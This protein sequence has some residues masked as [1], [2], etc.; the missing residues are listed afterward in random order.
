[1][2]LHEVGVGQFVLPI[3]IDRRMEPRS[4]SGDP[5]LRADD[6]I[7]GVQLERHLPLR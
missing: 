7:L 3:P 2:V 4:V 1:M 6:Q 5:A